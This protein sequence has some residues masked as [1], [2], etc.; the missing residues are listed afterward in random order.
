MCSVG[1]LQVKQFSSLQCVKTKRRIQL[2][3]VEPN[4]TIGLYILDIKNKKCDRESENEKKIT[5][6]T[7]TDTRQRKSSALGLFDV[8]CEGARKDTDY[9]RISYKEYHTCS[10]SSLVLDDS[11]SV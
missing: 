8:I 11:S 9:T 6:L 4:M 7:K 5:L 3:A 2:L 1:I 10:T